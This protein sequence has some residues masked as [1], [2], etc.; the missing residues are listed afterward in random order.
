MTTRR[1]EPQIACQRPKRKKG[2]SVSITSAL[3]PN[4]VKEASIWALVQD[5]PMCP[6][7]HKGARI[8]KLVTVAKITSLTRPGVITINTVMRYGELYPPPTRFVDPGSVSA[9]LP[10]FPPSLLPRRGSQIQTLVAAICGA[11]SLPSLSLSF[12]SVG[13]GKVR[14]RTYSPRLHTVR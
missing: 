7:S 9:V 4:H 1:G 3:R 12:Y 10:S 14:T 11:L 8:L 13:Q 2:P 5:R 6:T